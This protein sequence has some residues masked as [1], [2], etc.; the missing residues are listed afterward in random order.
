M[1][2]AGTAMRACGYEHDDGIPFLVRDLVPLLFW[3]A[4]VYFSLLL[5]PLAFSNAFHILKFTSPVKK[6]SFIRITI[7]QHSSLNF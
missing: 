1:V 3:P 7:K 6:K 2:G 5:D 4:S